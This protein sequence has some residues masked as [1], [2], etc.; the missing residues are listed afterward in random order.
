MHQPYLIHK[1]F[2]LTSRVFKKKYL[3]HKLYNGTTY[4]P[5]EKSRQFIQ[6]IDDDQYSDAVVRIRHQLD[7]VHTMNVQLH[8][9]YTIENITSTIIYIT[10]EYDQNKT[11]V[12]KTR[13]YNNKNSYKPSSSQDRY[14]QRTYPQ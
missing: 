12:R 10:N 13:Q 1:I 9:D 14:Q 6:G 3:L 4:T 2:I 5:L 8:D 7:T 11:V